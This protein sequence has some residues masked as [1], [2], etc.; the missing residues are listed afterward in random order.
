M[1]DA[2]RLRDIV[3]RLYDRSEQIVRGGFEIMAGCVAANAIGGGWYEENREPA[4]APGAHAMVVYNPQLLLRT[5]Y[6]SSS[7]KPRRNLSQPTLS[8]NRM[9]QIATIIDAEFYNESS[10]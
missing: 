3:K 8:Y 4:N 2:L 6:G 9:H 7:Y 10:H 1:T 5:I